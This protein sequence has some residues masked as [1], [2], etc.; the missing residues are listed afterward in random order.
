MGTIPGLGLGSD[1]IAGFPGETDDDFARTAALV[2]ELPFTYLHVFPYSERRGTE[3]MK[4][5]GGLPPAVVETRSRRLRRLAFDKS[6]AFRQ[7]LIGTVHEA[8]VLERRERSGGGL[9][10]LTGNYVEVSVDGP[11]ALKRQLVHVRVTGA[12]GERTVGTVLPSH[13]GAE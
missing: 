2:A 7:S 12:D 6:L 1:V 8:F 11:E 9:V 3:A 10:A 13:G 4:L 5:D